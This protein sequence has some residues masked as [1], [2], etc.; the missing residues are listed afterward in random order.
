MPTILQFTR[1][2]IVGFM[3]E[4]SIAPKRYL[5]NVLKKFEIF[6]TPDYLMHTHTHTHTHTLKKKPSQK[7]IFTRGKKYM[8]WKIC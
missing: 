7:K 5:K 2:V 6:A 3:R 1:L 8:P 4:N